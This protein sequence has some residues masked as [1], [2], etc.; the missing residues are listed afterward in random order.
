MSAFS[1]IELWRC[2][3]RFRMAFSHNLASRTRA[4]TLVAVVRGAG[5]AEGY[6]QAL[7]REYLTGESLDGVEQDIRERWWP[8]LRRLDLPDG[9]PFPTL[10][11]RLEPLYR[12]AD[13]DRALA[14]Y[15]A[16]ETAAVDAYLRAGKSLFDISPH[17]P[18]VMRLAGVIPAAEPKFAAG[19]AKVLHKLGYRRFK[20]KVGNDAERDHARLA[21]VRK[22]VGGDSRLA[23]DANAAWTWEEAVDRMRWLAEFGVDVV[24]EPLRREEGGD[25]RLLRE[26]SGRA[27]MVDESLCTLAD[28]R[29]LLERGSPDWWNIRL[30]K[31]GGFC[32]VRAL[33]DLA[34]KNGIHIYGGVLVGETSALAAAG[35][36]GMWLAGAAVGEYGFP[37]VLLRGDPFR[38][39]PGGYTG[40]ARPPRS[41]RPGLGVRLRRSL[42]ARAGRLSWRDGN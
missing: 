14:A 2:D 28:A 32:G 30:G 24:E 13:G 39:G 41:P 20:V 42:L 1:G 23:V 22:T 18:D 31:N 27:I 5:G 38:G 25:Y 34:R 19:M 36:A 15:G 3:F 16:A 9:L 26:L 40:T 17:A 35:R 11:D 21:A 7:P 4:E 33:A 8:R 6:G 37:R 29:R 10:L 12:E